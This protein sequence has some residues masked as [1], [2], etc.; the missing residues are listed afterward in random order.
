MQKV[1]TCQSQAK[2]LL[3]VSKGL[4]TNGVLL[5]DIAK[6]HTQTALVQEYR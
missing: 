3:W 2:G 6:V 1:S 4:G 5:S